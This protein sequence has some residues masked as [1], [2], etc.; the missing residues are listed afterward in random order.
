LGGFTKKIS[1]D[2]TVAFVLTGGC[3]AALTE[4][5]SASIYARLMWGE[6]DADYKVL[7]NGEVTE[8]RGTFSFPID[9]I[10]LGIGI[11]YRF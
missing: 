2:D 7:T 10:A 1:V 6:L 9:N 5:F 11:K 8:E 4:H 3:D